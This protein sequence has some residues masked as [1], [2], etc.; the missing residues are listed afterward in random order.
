MKPLSNV[1]ILVSDW[2]IIYFETDLRNDYGPSMC[3]EI[4]NIVY[5]VEEIKTFNYRS[6]PKS[7]LDKLRIYDLKAELRAARGK[8]NRD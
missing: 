3:P 8:I 7:E 5:P 2:L 1:F 6:I 4:P